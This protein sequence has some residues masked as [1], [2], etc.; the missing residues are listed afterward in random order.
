MMRKSLKS[1]ALVSALFLFAA[2]AIAKT[3]FTQHS[4]P[5][6]SAQPVKTFIPFN[7]SV[8]LN[9]NHLLKRGIIN[10]YEGDY[11]MASLLLHRSLRRSS[12][13]LG[14]YYMG[15][16]KAKIGNTRTAV[17]HLKRANSVYSNAPETYAALGEA[18]AKLGQN[19]KARQTL[20]Q[21]NALKT[22][23]INCP[24]AQDIKRA[25]DTIE[26]SLGINTQ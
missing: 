25:R 2:P 21:L 23:S 22:C 3:P 26:A 18:Y 13:P 14:H 16:T 9:S 5:I 15:L 11:T 6:N 1:A 17:K 24:S 12:N 4:E 19:E 20:A 10:Y 8:D 7:G